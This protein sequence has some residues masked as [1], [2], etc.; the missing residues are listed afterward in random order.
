M[1]F[2]FTKRTTMYQIMSVLQD[3]ITIYWSQKFHLVFIELLNKNYYLTIIQNDYNQS[4]TFNK[5][6]DSFNRCPNKNEL[7]NQTFVKLPFIRR[8]KYY[9]T[10]KWSLIFN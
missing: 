1:N 4:Q 6:K 8:I 9:W 5:K 3:S 2:E 10:F 7:F